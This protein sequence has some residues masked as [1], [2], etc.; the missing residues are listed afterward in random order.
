MRKTTYTC[1]I[2][3]SS[4]KFEEFCDAEDYLFE[5]GFSHIKT[6]GKTDYY[7]KD[8]ETARIFEQL[9]QWQSRRADIWESSSG[10]FFICI[11]LF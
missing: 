6:V 8:G 1:T 7:E 4:K 10:S 2:K 3:D 5:Q 9:E 11:H